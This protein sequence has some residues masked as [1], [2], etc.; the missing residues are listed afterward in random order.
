L[1]ARFE[2]KRTNPAFR[3]LRRRLLARRLKRLDLVLRGEIVL[4]AAVV[5]AFLFWQARIPLDSLGRQRGPAA[6]A[7]ALAGL[8]GLIVVGGAALVGVRHAR[9]LRGERPA[10]EW[11]ALPIPVAELERH[12]AWESRLHLAWAAAFAPGFLLAAV[13]LVPAAWLVALALVF[14]A[15]LVGA[16][17]IAT[18]LA[19]R[20][21]MGGAPNPRG[22]TLYDLLAESPRRRTVGRLGS[23][24]WRRGPPWLALWRK[25]A[26]VSTRPTAARSRAVAPVVLVAASAGCWLVPLEPP[27]AHLLAFACALMAAAATAEWI[28]SLSSTDPFEI[29][30]GLPLGAGAVWGSRASWALVLAAAIVAGN[31]AT[32]RSLEPAALHV[33]LV[34]GFCAS[35]A[36]GLLGVHY[37]MTLFPR[38]DLAQRFLALT[39]GIAMAASLMIP[40]LGWIVLLTAVLHSARR[41]PRWSRMEPDR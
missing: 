17:S 41:V 5:G 20:M 4:L 14:V 23:V 37:G 35:L 30:R 38:A 27:M 28:V 34:W 8:L 39:L 24:R 16:G 9:R 13:G 26:L 19:L 7:I 2:V 21:A 33:F 6:V 25:D 22:E 29:L 18:A 10:H 15:A 1:R 3:W 12:L 31:A 32:A 11:L 36:I 40:L